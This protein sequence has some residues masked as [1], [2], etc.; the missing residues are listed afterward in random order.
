MPRSE[1]PS[2]RAMFIAVTV[3]LVGTL[4]VV[5]CGQS[6]SSAIAPLA[7]S[8]TTSTATSGVASSG[9][10]K[11]GWAPGW[12]VSNEPLDYRN[13]EVD[14]HQPGASSNLQISY[15]LVAA[16]ANWG[17]QVGVH[18]F[19][20]CDPAFGNQPSIIPCSRPATRQGVSRNVQAFDF[21]TPISTD[22]SGNGTGGYVVQGIAPGDYDLEF[23]VRAGVGC[24]NG[25]CNVVFQSPGPFGNTIRVSIH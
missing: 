5:G 1:E 2:M 24:P 23:D 8:S 11:A 21:A 17:Y 12:D 20:R 7:P 10:I 4:F 3:V 25:P 16:R 22:A 14:W 6:S 19:D 9:L 18:L 15:R 13:S